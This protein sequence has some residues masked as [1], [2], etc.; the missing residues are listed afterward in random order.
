MGID[1]EAEV[2]ERLI[3]RLAP[4]NQ[5]AP[6]AASTSG[7]GERASPKRDRRSGVFGYALMAW[8]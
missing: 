8:P 1:H 3:A 6:L 7:A 2:A 4:Q 5:T